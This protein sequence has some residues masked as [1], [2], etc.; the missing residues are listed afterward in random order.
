MFERTEGSGRD[1]FL[2]VNAKMLLEEMGKQ[3]TTVTK[4]AGLDGC[5]WIKGLP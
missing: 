2:S 1:L 3:C 5:E 4:T